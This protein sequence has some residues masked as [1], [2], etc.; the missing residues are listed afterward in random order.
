MKADNLNEAIQRAAKKVGFAVGRDE[1]GFV[2]H[3]FRGF[4]KSHC[5]KQGS[6]CC[7]RH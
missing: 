2:S 4:F 5:I 6:L 1:G 7:R 3:S